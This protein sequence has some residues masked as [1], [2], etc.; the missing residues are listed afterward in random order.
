MYLIGESFYDNIDDMSDINGLSICPKNVWCIIKIW[1]ADA[2][3]DI[4]KKMPPKIVDKF[5]KYSIV[6]KKN[7]P[8]D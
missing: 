1:N 8:E 4:S 7:E 2:S 3:N 6:Y 5:S